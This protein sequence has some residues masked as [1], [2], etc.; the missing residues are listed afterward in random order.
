MGRLIALLIAG[1]TFVMSTATAG[2]ASPWEFVLE[3]N[4]SQEAWFALHYQHGS[5]GWRTEGWL[6][7][8]P[9]ERWASGLFTDNRTFYYSAFSAG[10]VWAGTDAFFS[11]DDIPAE[12]GFHER[13]IETDGGTW[14]VGIQCSDPADHQVRVYTCDEDIQV[15]LRFRNMDGEWQTRGFFRLEPN[16]MYRLARMS[17]RR[18][19]L[20]ASRRDWSGRLAA[21]GVSESRF[22]VRGSTVTFLEV[23]VERM[24]TVFPVYC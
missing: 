17:D 21:S 18:F 8:A 13:R 6:I 24:N 7:V 19:F 4:C 5:A 23:D 2:K 14:T 22:D 3:N 12:H 20:H 11:V 16:R 10:S 15:A 1:F 9:G